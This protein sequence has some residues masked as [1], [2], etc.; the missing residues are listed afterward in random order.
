M[1]RPI[2]TREKIAIQF[3]LN[4]T[5]IAVLIGCNWRNAKR[6]FDEANKVDDEELS[7]RVEPLKVRMQ[8]VLK[9]AGISQKQLDSVIERKQ[10]KMESTS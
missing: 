8:T 3:Y 10:Q 2:K 1:P 9:L 4:T 5:D 7:F 6:L